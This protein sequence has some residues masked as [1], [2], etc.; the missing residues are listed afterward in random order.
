MTKHSVTSTKCRVTTTTPAKI[1][2]ALTITGRLDNDYHLLDSLFLPVS[3]F[4]N[5]AVEFTLRT[6]SGPH[7]SSIVCHCSNRPE[8][9]GESNIATRAASLLLTETGQSADVE[10]TIDKQIWT[11]AG[12]GGGS[13]DAAAVLTMINKQLHEHGCGLTEQQLADLALRL[14]ADVPFF[15][16]PQPCR[17]QGIGEIISPLKGLPRLH[18][19]LTNPGKPLGTREVY[20][21]LGITRGTQRPVDPLPTALDGS[22]DQVLSLIRNDLE[23][24]AIRLCAE[25]AEL[26]KRLQQHGALAASMS[27]SGATVFGLFE[28]ETAAQKAVTELSSIL[29]SYVVYVTTDAP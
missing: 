8:L 18:L 12:L 7:E 23:L 29:G 27:G 28:S 11:A 19:V 26:K 4:D 5:I 21:H 9:D 14:G 2:L 3:L 17:I 24:P 10:I 25:V 22:L 20:E 16:K 13:S 15:L 6:T 1:N